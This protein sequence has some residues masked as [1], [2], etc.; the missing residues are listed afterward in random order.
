MNSNLTLIKPSGIRLFNTMAAQYP[1]CIRFT[2]GEPDFNSDE[3]VKTATINALKQNN[4]RYTPNQGSESLRAAISNYLDKT[5][6]QNYCKDEI[7][8]TIGAGEALAATLKSILNPQDEVICL[9][10]AYPAYES[11]IKL[12]HAHFVPYDI[13]TNH[14]Q[15]DEQVLSTLITP[16]TKAIIINSPNNPS[17]TILNESSLSAIYNCVKKQKIFVISDDIY[18]QMHYEDCPSIARYQDIREQLIFIQSFSKSYAMQGY[19]IGFV[20]ADISIIKYI[21]LTHAFWLSCVAGFIQEG[22]RVALNSDNRSMLLAYRQR[23]D[24]LCQLL[25]NAKIPYIKPQGAFYIFIDIK[26][27][28]LNSY[29]FAY[30]LLHQHH[31]CVIP[32]RYFGAGFDNYIRLSYATDEASIRTGLQ[33]L[34]TF[35]NEISAE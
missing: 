26:S 35:I 33:R 17:G 20:F 5:Y 27:Y 31:V 32:G 12:E 16:K 28:H 22:A 4:T 23:R 13:S 30:R 1:D 9:T 6:H 3:L 14:F 10:P 24:L 8:V 2:L 11:L 18:V 29:D 7:L 21:T 15:I 34:L 19:R 25:D